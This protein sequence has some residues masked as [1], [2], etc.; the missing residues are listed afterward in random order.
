LNLD[1]FRHCLLSLQ[2]HE[3]SYNFSVI[4]MA[5]LSVP[6]KCWGSPILARYLEGFP[7]PCAEVWN[8]Q[9]RFDTVQCNVLCRGADKQTSAKSLIINQNACKSESSVCNLEIFVLRYREGEPLRNWS[10]NLGPYGML[11]WKF[12]FRSR[13]GLKIYCKN[14]WY[15]SIWS[16]VKYFRIIMDANLIVLPTLNQ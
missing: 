15:S 10:W 8:F 16:E 12:H 11:Q 14:K 2:G 9:L 6:K 4:I 1:Y 3:W 7:I 13:E 5:L